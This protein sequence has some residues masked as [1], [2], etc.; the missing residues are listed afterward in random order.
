[1]MAWALALIRLVP[2][3][4]WALVAALGLG[5]AYVKRAERAAYW[6]GYSAALEKVEQANAEARRKASEGEAAV[7]ACHRAGKEWN[8][9]T[10]QCGS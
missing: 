7:I 4:A 5:L 1:M 6:S 10:G 2:W 3:Q 8:R 9:E